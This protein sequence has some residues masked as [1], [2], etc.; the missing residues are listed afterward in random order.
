MYTLENSD[1]NHNISQKRFCAVRIGTVKFSSLIDT[2]A[3]IS[4][5][6]N[7]VFKLLKAR[8]NSLELYDLSDKTITGINNSC[9]SMFGTWDMLI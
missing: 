5:I 8:N 2:G 7:R 9:T 6:S 3:Q 4:V 1:C